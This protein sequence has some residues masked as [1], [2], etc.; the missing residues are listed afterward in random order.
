MSSAAPRPSAHPGTRRPWLYALWYCE[1][2]LAAA[3]IWALL[4]DRAPAT[5]VQATA[6]LILCGAALAVPAHALR[7]LLIR[8]GARDGVRVR[9]LEAFLVLAAAGTAAALSTAH[10]W[11]AIVCILL[12]GN[13]LWALEL[14]SRAAKRARRLTS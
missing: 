4:S 1:G 8:R 10:G 3:A 11:G 7:T 5:L 12:I 14:E 6:F 9:L 13:A 2:C